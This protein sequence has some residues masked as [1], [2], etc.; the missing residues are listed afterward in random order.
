MYI[1]GS[2]VTNQCIKNISQETLDDLGEDS[3]GSNQN[4]M[5]KAT[6]DFPIEAKAQVASG[7]ELTSSQVN[8]NQCISVNIFKCYTHETNSYVSVRFSW[9]ALD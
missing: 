5:A 6:E 8:T 4:E 3:K 2:E 9:F 7:S 1:I